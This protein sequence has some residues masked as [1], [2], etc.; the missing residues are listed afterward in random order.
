MKKVGERQQ[1]RV[2]EAL[3]GL[4]GSEIQA[5]AEHA[6]SLGW[7]AGEPVRSLTENVLLCV[8][9]MEIQIDE[10]WYPCF[11]AMCEERGYEPCVF[12]GTVEDAERELMGT[13]DECVSSIRVIRNF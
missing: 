1:I 13:L 2:T 5:A 6:I 9:D 4:S 7:K 3:L 11:V 10:E 12:V 8:P